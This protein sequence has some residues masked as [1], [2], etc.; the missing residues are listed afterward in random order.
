MSID[1]M[2]IHSILKKHARY[3]SL[4]KITLKITVLTGRYP[5]ENN[6]YS[7]MF[8]HT[9]NVEYVK[10][11]HRVIVLVPAKISVEYEMDGVKVI[12]AD[13]TTLVKYLIDS[14]RIMIH[15]LLH[16]FDKNIDAGVLYDAVLKEHLPTVFFIHGIETQTIWHSRR[17]DIKW[18]NPRTIARWLYRDY[19][20]IKRMI[21]TLNN[22]NKS[23]F[24]CKFVSPSK[25][26]LNESRRHT[27]IDLTSKSLVI[28]NGID[29]ERFKF[30][31]RW[32]KRQQLL[33]IRPLIYKGTSAID[34]LIDV[35]S[36][37]SHD[38]N[39]VLYGRGNDEEL[40]RNMADKFINKLHFQL[41][42]EFIN[43]QDIP[44]I[45]DNHGMYL[46][47]TRMDSQG[48]SMC[49]AMASGLPTISFDTCA[50]PEFI[51]H[52]NTGLLAEANN[53]EQFSN[54]I[55]ELVENRK[56]FDKLTINARKAM[57]AIDVTKTTSQ[58]LEM[59]I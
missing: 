33:S 50:I 13:V 32:E 16:R 52:N 26:M 39:L 20:L 54:H 31:D 15:L 25:W 42:A 1:G 9:R 51:E 6:P 57:E 30:V 46:A 2:L 35:A 29:T 41:K 45:H 48:V 8:V 7:H 53:V 19:Y 5:S 49:E 36:Q 11:G 21:K 14:D 28:P 18:H 47:V 22:F 3:Q 10:K 58:E 55:N 12:L 4:G 38:F 56:L 27:G 43:H 59:K 37:L 44:N 17:E 40:I 23:D 34:L 24:P